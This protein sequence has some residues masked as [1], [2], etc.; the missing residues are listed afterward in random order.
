MV[1]TARGRARQSHAQQ[2]AH[3]PRAVREDVV[4]HGL[5]VRV[6]QA[7]AVP[8]K[9]PSRSE[10]SNRRSPANAS[11]NPRA[12]RRC[13][14]RCGR[15]SATD[16]APLCARAP[17]HQTRDPSWPSSAYSAVSSSRA[18]TSQ[19]TRGR[20]RGHIPSTSTG[21]AARARQ[22]HPRSARCASA[23]STHT[24]AERSRERGARA[25]SRV[26]ARASECVLRPTR[27]AL[28]ATFQS[29]RRTEFCSMMHVFQ[30]TRSAGAAVRRRLVRSSDRSL[31]TVY[32]Y[33]THYVLRATVS[34]SQLF[35]QSSHAP[36]APSATSNSRDF[37][38]RTSKTS[39]RPKSRASK[40]SRKKPPPPRFRRR[41][42]PPPAGFFQP[43]RHLDARYHV[44]VIIPLVIT[45]KNDGS[46]VALASRNAAE[47]RGDLS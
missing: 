6:Q 46:A 43:P 15:A 26:A 32:V 31:R 41:R 34:P 30:K 24:T 35:K 11:Q 47:K 45:K 5:P 7:H 14:A 19:D 2:V 1:P 3:V 27:W 9:R 17:P 36:V 42:R 21:S 18:M 33:A 16:A 39:T 40:T 29:S 8:A 37:E 4:P 44:V 10:P 38:N 13:A 20:V 12:S 22:S 28:G 25:R 23:R